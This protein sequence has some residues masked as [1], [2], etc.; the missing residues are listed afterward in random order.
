LKIIRDEGVI[1]L[2]C[3]CDGSIPRGIRPALPDSKMYLAEGIPLEPYKL[4]NNFLLRYIT[5]VSKNK[6]G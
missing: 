3:D 2:I 5:F 6:V 1:F 4:A